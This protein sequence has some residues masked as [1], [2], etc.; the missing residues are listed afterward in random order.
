MT[1]NAYTKVREVFHQVCDLDPIEQ[2]EKI[3]TLCAGDQSTKA[4]VLRLLNAL[5]KSHTLGESISDSFDIDVAFPII[6]GYTLLRVLGEGGMGTVYEALQANPRR[7]VSIKVIRYGSQNT[8]LLSR[9]KREAD[10]LARLK[11]P[12]I[13]QIYATGFCK[14]ENQSR[15]YIALELIE[16][17]SLLKYADAAKLDTQSRL[18]I[19]CM[20][21]DAVEHAHL[22]GVIH[23]DLKPS[24]ILVDSTGQPKIL[25]FGVARI[26]DSDVQALTLQ[27]EAGQILGTAAY[28]SPEQA[29]GIPSNIDIRSDIYSLGVVIYELLTGRRPHKIENLPIPDAILAIRENEPTRIG[30]IDTRYK[31][32]I[33]TILAKALER[34]I[35]RRYQTAGSLG[36]DIRRFIRN[37]P[38]VARPP[39]TLYKLRKFTSRNKA[40]VIGLAAVFLSLSLGLVGTS[41][42]FRRE[43][44]ARKQTMVALAEAQGST[45][46]LE[47]LLLGLD[48]SETQGRDTELLLDMLDISVSSVDDIP[49]PSVRAEMLSIIGRAYFVIFEYERAAEVFEKSSQVYHTLPP[50]HASSRNLVDRLLADSKRQTGQMEEAIELL[51]D[52]IT[53]IKQ[54]DT[55]EELIAPNT[56]LGEIKMVRGDWAGAL[57]AIELSREL[58]ALSSMEIEPGLDLLH[59]MLLRRLERYDEAESSYLLALKKYQSQGDPILVSKVSAAMALLAK[60]QGNYQLAEQRYRK[61][62]QLRIEV[63][64]RINPEVAIITSNLGR[65]LAEQDRFEEAIPLLEESIQMHIEIY[66]EDYFAIAFP[67]ASIARAKNKL[68]HHEEAIVLMDQ[69]LER[70]TTQFGRSHPVV[71]TSLSDKGLFLTNSTQYAQARQCY[72]ESLSII[73]ELNLSPVVY[74]APVRM[75]LADLLILQELTEDAL[76]CLITAIE[77][78][79][80]PEST[81]SLTIQARIRELT[82]QIHP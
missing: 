40:L 1:D 52:L 46:F 82:T 30:S 18:K 6:E 59:G 63:D 55:P 43:S 75:R 7:R 21:C 57:K 35:T 8:N 50:E 11:H 74:E 29:S 42:A 65:L 51:N 76:A 12:G 49:Y 79:N 13:A 81:L 66:G 17:E 32:D 23:R 24:N 25:D 34:D 56:L 4:E 62:L 47:N 22:Q 78:L 2:L 38:I 16:G 60:N 77:H 27:T 9:F 64:Q 15:P 67:T 58:S 39:T 70:F 3:D 20:L 71:A 45:E 28:M 41:I 19:A 72:N 31:G 37:E 48:P 14:S 69:A 36:D 61:A 54:D 73:E 5:N 80:A 33:E 26:T 53:R 44:T 68:G 10:V